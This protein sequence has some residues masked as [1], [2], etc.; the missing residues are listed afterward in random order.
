MTKSADVMAACRILWLKTRAADVDSK[1]SF[2][3][4]KS[5]GSLSFSGK[6]LLEALLR[7]VNQ[8]GHL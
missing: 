4:K 8:E 7:E 1:Q 2:D 5:L 6:R 3:S